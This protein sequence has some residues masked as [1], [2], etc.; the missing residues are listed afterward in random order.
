MNKKLFILIALTLIC[1]LL[2]AQTITISPTVTGTGFLPYNNSSG[3]IS[4]LI[5]NTNPFPAVLTQL[6]YW[7]STAVTRDYVLWQAPTSVV[8]PVTFPLTL[9]SGFSPIAFV[10]GVNMGAGVQTVIFPALS[11]TIPA[12]TAYRFYLTSST[13]EYTG[14]AITPLPPTPPTGVSGVS[15]LVFSNSGVNLMVAEAQFA[16]QYVGWGGGNFSPRAFLG[17][18][19]LN[20]LSSP[21]V[22]QPTAGTA[23]ASPNNPC[24]G[25]NVTLQ[26]T[27]T[28]AASGLAYQWQRSTTG[29]APWFTIPGATSNPYL[30]T[31]PPSSTTFYRCIVTCTFS[32]LNDTSNITS[33]A[34]VVQPYSV[35]SPCY[36]NSLVTNTTTSDIGRFALGTYSN[37]TVA[38]TPQTANAAATGGYT[39]NLSL[40]PNPTVTQGISYPVSIYQFTSA[41]A[42]SNC[43][44]KVWIDFNQN[45]NFTD[46]GEEVF[47]SS[48]DLTNG[49]SPSGN[50]T[51]PPSALPGSTRMRVKLE[52][53]G[54]ATTTTPCNTITTGE[55][56]DYKLTINSAGPHD[57]T[58]TA[59]TA[60]SSNL[61][62]GATE[63]VT[64][65][66]CNYGSTPVNLAIYPYIVTLKVYGPTG[67]QTQVL[68]FNTGTLPPYG[69]GCLTASGTFNMFTGGNYCVNA[70]VSCPTNPFNNFTTND[71]LPSPVCFFNYRPV[72][73]PY[74]MCQ[75]NSIPFGQGLGVGGCSSPIND[76]VTITFSVGVCNDN[77]GSTLNGTSPGPPSNASDQYAC[78]FGT[79]ILPA[80]PPGAT[81]PVPATLKV[82]NLAENPLVPATLNT[83]MR[84]NLYKN[85]PV[86]ANLLSPGG[87]VGTASPPLAVTNWTYQRNVSPANL[88]NIFSSIPVGGTL[89]LG[90]W[91]SYQDNISM[92]DI[93][94]NSGGTTVAT[95]TIPYQ[96]VPPTFAWYDVPSGGTNLYSLSPFDPLSVPNAL[97][98]NSNTP[99]TFTFYAACLGLTNCRVPVDLTINPTPSACQDSMIT[100]EYLPGANSGIFNLCSI[101][102]SVSCFNAAASV[103]YYG[104]QSLLLPIA[105]SNDTSSTNFIYSKVFYPATG[106]YSSDSV[107]LQVS[108]IPVFTPSNIYSGFACAPSSVDVSSLIT[109]FSLTPTD[110]TFWQD[111]AH[112]LPFPNP[113]AI[114]VADTVYIVAKTSDSAACTATAT[115][116][117]DVLPATTLIANQAA[118]NYSNCGTVPCGV[119]N[120]T[121]GNTETLYTT[122]DCRRIATV[123]DSTDAIS[124]GAVSICEEIDCTQGVYNGQPYLN[125]HYE[126]TPTNNGKAVV[127]LYYL[128]D[129][130]SSYNSA[131]FP[132][133]QMDPTLNNLC[134]TQIDN[135]VLGAPGS[136]ATVIQNA[137]ITKTFDPTTTIWTVCFPVDSFSSFYCHTCNPIPSAA[138]PVSL[139]NF[140]GQR[141]NGQS[142]LTWVSSSEQN[143]SH[144]I[145]ERS[146]DAKGYAGISPMIPSKA[147]GGNSQVKLNYGFT[148]AK[149]LIGHNY[150]RLRQVDLDGHV[151]YSKTIDLFY[152]N[153][154]LVSLYPNPVSA[155]LNVEIQTSRNSLATMRIIDAAGRVVKT[156][157]FNLL[158]GKNRSQVNLSDLSDG[159][160]MVRIADDNGLDFSQVVRKQ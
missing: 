117:I 73:S 44:A 40:S 38:P 28:T 29:G 93:A 88:S 16:G 153:D 92:S 126:I 108:S 34:V 145:V 143:N 43:W 127:C 42:L 79:A 7:N 31:P 114:S 102:N 134:I 155:E 3:G 48:S 160:Y 98:N 111:A 52:T 138:L 152:S 53:G 32:G 82:T 122:T 65:T 60:P 101:Q 37:P 22:G 54:S 154:A 62:P 9:A 4:F 103:E 12:N 86:G 61:C 147:I 104:D 71:S 35:T 57:P 130:F 119:I 80:L 13:V 18:V 157:A 24:P 17:S 141:L 100:C 120:L 33:P 150:Y 27:G 125:R 99:G 89:S 128:D 68:T 14:T 58:I 129:D 46:P 26:L 106:C 11:Y 45:T 75:Y 109:L 63:L 151:S 69:A 115:A 55:V 81:F 8:M 72:A 118:G 112:T 64:A 148:D 30:Y 94:I 59:V 19:T 156:N 77:V 133:W 144:F 49:Y 135:G 66:V 47:S 142:E 121:D 41:S 136:V 137:A 116:Y 158:E 95:L 85:T 50:I 149:P 21:C 146:Q 113:H 132:Y 2:N 87:A 123:K 56:E 23:S 70:S 51:I 10:N 15:P 105:C 36:C 6:T 97:V 140:T 139:L 67:L 1:R 25:T 159:V 84:L 107:Y 90:Y 83:E 91:E 74:T 20:L 39:N 5:Q 124:L 110:T 131:A 78:Q 96:Y 76:T